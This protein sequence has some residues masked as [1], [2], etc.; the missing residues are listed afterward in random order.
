[1]VSCG[2]ATSMR[3]RYRY[4]GRDGSRWS[5]D[6]DGRVH[7]RLRRCCAFGFPMGPAS[8]HTQSRQKSGLVGPATC[9]HRTPVSGKKGPSR[10]TKREYRGRGRSLFSIGSIPVLARAPWGRPPSSRS[11]GGNVLAGGRPH[12]NVRFPWPG[13]EHLAARPILVTPLSATAGGRS[14]LLRRST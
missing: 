3:A 13:S 4:R 10:E 8:G 11:R 9:R 6:A 7:R 2:M 12:F 5:N 1:M 14:P